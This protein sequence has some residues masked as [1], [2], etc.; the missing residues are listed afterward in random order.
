MHVPA[1][2]AGKFFFRGTG[3]P[4]AVRKNRPLVPRSNIAGSWTR[5][6]GI[7]RTADNHRRGEPP[8]PPSSSTPSHASDRF[9][10]VWLSNLPPHMIAA[11]PTAQ[12]ATADL[13]QHARVVLV[14]ASVW[15]GCAEACIVRTGQQWTDP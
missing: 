13:V 5:G 4:T 7:I 12:Q 11:Q 10:L 9:R 1:Q 3:L 2:R 6:G 8:Q 15:P 14:I